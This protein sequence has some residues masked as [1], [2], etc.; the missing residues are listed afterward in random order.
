VWQGED[1]ARWSSSK[2]AVAV[3][4]LALTAYHFFDDAQRGPYKWNGDAALMKTSPHTFAPLERDVGRYLKEHTRPDDTVFVYS[5]GENAHVVL[6]FAERRTASPFF[7]SFWLDPIGLLPQSK[8]QPTASE[9]AALEA[10]QTTVRERACGAI[11]QHPPA[12]MAFN[13]LPQVF[14]VCPMIEGMLR[15]SYA[16]ATTMGAFHIYLRRPSAAH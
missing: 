8:N 16:E 2:S 1:P 15:T 4:A 6:Y 5:A 11:Q 13:L 12:A 3:L 9:R 10:V 14:K 7:H